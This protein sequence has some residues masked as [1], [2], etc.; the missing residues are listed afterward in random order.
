M[1]QLARLVI[2]ASLVCV[3]AAAR[4]NDGM[5]TVPSKYSVSETADRMESAVRRI[6]PP[7]H[8]F[9]R[10]DLQT[11]AATQG[12]AVRPTQL[13]IFGRGTISAM[14]LPSNPTIGLDLPLK[15]LVWEDADGKVWLTYNTG[16]Y[17]M[18]R[19]GAAARDDLAR[20]ISQVTAELASAATE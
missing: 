17:I 7:M 3:A 8:F 2:A 1:K 15:A 4:A 20:R 5:V 6:Q 11:T 19:H 18:Q 16:A 12:G 13:L 9:T 10:I 14:L